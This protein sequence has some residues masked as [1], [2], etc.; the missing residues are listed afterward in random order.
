MISSELMDHVAEIRR[1]DNVIYFSFSQ[2][3]CGQP[4]SFFP[5]DGLQYFEQLQ[6]L[7]EVQNFT[8]GE[9]SPFFSIPF[10]YLGIREAPVQKH[11]QVP[12]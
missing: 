2:N 7:L 10:L 1:T 12:G 6:L 5:T 9:I 3:A 4:N 11:D 8:P